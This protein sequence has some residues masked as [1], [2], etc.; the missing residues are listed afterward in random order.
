MKQIKLCFLLYCV[1]FLLSACFMGTNKM[2]FKSP[3]PS[4]DKIWICE[5]PFAYFTWNDGFRGEIILDNTL[6][7]CAVG[8]SYGGWVEFLLLEGEDISN[9]FDNR[10][11]LIADFKYSK[12]ILKLSV[13]KDAEGFRYTDYYDELIFT[14]YDFNP[15]RDELPRPAGQNG[16]TRKSKSARP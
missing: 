11:L 15:K 1:T 8:F 7:P 2:F 6:Y 5:E 9:E 13:R 14:R 12:D 3:E 16:K 4:R 10:D